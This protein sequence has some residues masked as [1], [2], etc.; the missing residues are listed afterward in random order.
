MLRR[1]FARPALVLSL[2]W[3]AADN[4]RAASVA[5][6]ALDCALAALALLS[7][8]VAVHEMPRQRRTTHILQ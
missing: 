4:T 5:I 6:I 1:S 2:S 7:M 3:Q 8:S